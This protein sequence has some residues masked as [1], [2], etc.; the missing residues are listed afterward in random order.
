MPRQRSGTKV[1]HQKK[2]EVPQK[3][4]FTKFFFMF[5]MVW[6]VK[7]KQTRF[8]RRPI[9][10][11]LWF[12]AIFCEKSSSYFKTVGCHGTQTST[13]VGTGTDSLGYPSQ[14]KQTKR[15]QPQNDC[16]NVKKNSNERRKPW[17]NLWSHKHYLERSKSNQYISGFNGCSLK[18][19]R[20][21]AL[22]GTQVKTE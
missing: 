8:F 10:L 1:V 2:V 5:Q 6:N 3:R 19:W 11:Q 13:A 18:E 12:Y 16:G 7:V 15:L 17:R 14:R 20:S 9:T 22:H 21:S 4:N